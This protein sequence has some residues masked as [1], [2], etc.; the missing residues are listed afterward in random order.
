M[1]SGSSAANLPDFS[2][3]T[4]HVRN[5]ADTLDMELDKISNLAAVQDGARWVQLSTRVD[6]HEDRLTEVQGTVTVTQGDITALQGDFTVLRGDFIALR[7]DFTALGGD[8]TALRD[9][10]TTL[11]RDVSGMEQ[12]ISRFQSDMRSLREEFLASREQSLQLGRNLGS[13]SI[14]IESMNDRLIESTQEQ[15]DARIR[16][17]AL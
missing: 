2:A 3:A 12:N 9:A 1:D 7:G 8:F 13:L 16:L 11:R 4:G 15:A 6:G 17:E 14:A 10:N 5:F